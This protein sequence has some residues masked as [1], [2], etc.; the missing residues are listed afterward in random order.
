MI[1]PKL[2][3]DRKTEKN[4]NSEHKPW[5]HFEEETDK[6]ELRMYFQTYQ[7]CGACQRTKISKNSKTE[8]TTRKRLGEFFALM[9]TEEEGSQ[10]PAKG[11]L[12]GGARL[13]NWLHQQC[14][15]ERL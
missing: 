15:W 7:K 12:S 9:F 3:P 8:K 14:Q 4:I 13:R 6:T 1:H 2:Y 11:L 10:N 5:K